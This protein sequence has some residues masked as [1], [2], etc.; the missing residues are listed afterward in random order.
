MICGRFG[1]RVL[2][3]SILGVFLRGCR[4]GETPPV[5]P[6]G[7][8]REGNL[9]ILASWQQLGCLA[10]GFGTLL[11]VIV[12]GGRFGDMVQ[13]SSILGGPG[14]SS[15]AGRSFYTILGS[16]LGGIGSPCST[17]GESGGS[18][19]AIFR[20]RGRHFAAPGRHP[21]HP[22]AKTRAMK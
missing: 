19:L 13:K 6:N 12:I 16:I 4:R 8:A 2:K 22:A 21:R 11:R 15:V 5:R 10:A 7:L 1:D 3:T 17:L 14:G 9:D 18:S 20:P